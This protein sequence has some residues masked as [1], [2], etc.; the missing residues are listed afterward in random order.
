MAEVTGTTG[1]ALGNI[2]L[3]TV[4][5][6]KDATVTLISGASDTILS[7]V[8]GMI[9]TA[10]STVWKPGGSKTSG[11]L[12]STLLVAA[13]EG[14][15][16]NI[17]GSDNV[18]TTSDWLEGAGQ[19]VLVGT[20]VAVV[21]VQSGST[22]VYKFNA[23]APRD[24]SVVRTV[25][26]NTPDSDGNVTVSGGFTQ[27]NIGPGAIY[28]SGNPIV[29]LSG[30]SGVSVYYSGSGI[31]FDGGTLQSAICGLSCGMVTGGVASGTSSITTDA[32]LSVSG[33][34][35]VVPFG[36]TNG[37]GLVKLS[38]SIGSSS[39]IAVTEYAVANALCGVYSTI[40]SGL[41]TT[42]V[43]SNLHSGLVAK[44]LPNP[45]TWSGNTIYAM[46]A[47]LHSVDGSSE[48]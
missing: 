22:T 26:G 10:I 27:F 48:S 44:S 6:D 41:S 12:T 30:K 23:L 15:V 7:G 39:G 11:Q 47:A 25:N 4:M 17:S 8:S 28:A 18:T 1:M 37:Y 38:N 5:V 29:T 3:N 40:S 45:S 24:A 46:L 35:I 31:Y 14:Y 34:K 42:V 43:G 36:D 13:N 16:Y 19:T 32:N 2:P 9:G 33:G 21:A 20:D